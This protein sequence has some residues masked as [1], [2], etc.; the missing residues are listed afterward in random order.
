MYMYRL[1]H[2]SVSN[3]EVSIESKPSGY[4]LQWSN[5]LRKQDGLCY[6]ETSRCEEFAYNFTLLVG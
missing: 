5:W 6:G 4:S 1:N 2:C 3:Y